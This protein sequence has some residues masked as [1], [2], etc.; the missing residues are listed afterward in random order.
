MKL[1]NN[2]L[3]TFGNY[4]SENGYRIVDAREV[5][6]E[7]EFKYGEGPHRVITDGLSISVSQALANVVEPLELDSAIHRNFAALTD[8]EAFVEFASRF[9]LLGG[10]EIPIEIADWS[11]A[12]MITGEP[13]EIWLKEV[14]S[15]R[16][17]ISLW[18]WMKEGAA[19]QLARYFDIEKPQLSAKAQ[20][21]LV[22]G[23]P[24]SATALVVK[25]MVQNNLAGGVLGNLDGDDAALAPR[26][27]LAPINL[28]TGLWF[29]FA[30]EINDQR[31]YKSCAQCG[32]WMEVRTGSRRT[33]RLYCSNACRT[34]THHERQVMARQMF[35]QGVS[36]A[37]IAQK[38]ESDVSTIEKWTKRNDGKKQ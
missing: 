12:R 35:D 37:D 28:R 29:M 38:M 8:E 18:D 34:K 16:T 32:K 3:A 13:V 10:V 22:T 24:V 7:G 21:F 15:L 11:P 25:K 14:K 9:G 19:E 2:V 17:A 23:D 33:S 26:I 20:A 5:A 27:E 4:V 6:E 1:K 36:V 30:A 31:Q